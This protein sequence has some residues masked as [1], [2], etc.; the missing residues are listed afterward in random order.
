[1]NIAVN[2]FT[3]EDWYFLWTWIKAS[4]QCHCMLYPITIQKYKLGTDFNEIL[5]KIR[6]FLFKKRHLKMLFAKLWPFCL[7]LNLLSHCDIMVCNMYFEITIFELFPHFNVPINHLLWSRNMHQT[8]RFKLKCWMLYKTQVFH[9][10]FMNGNLAWLQQMR[11]ITSLWGF[12]VQTTLLPIYPLILHRN[13]YTGM[14]MQIEIENG[15]CWIL[16]FPFC[17][18]IMYT[19]LL[20]YYIHFRHFSVTTMGCGGILRIYLF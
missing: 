17:I 13:C 2:L 12:I 15:Q 3:L 19:L 14:L 6:P 10:V 18:I 20:T 11:S 4:Q 1:M 16:W 9:N 5:I 7:M 8:T